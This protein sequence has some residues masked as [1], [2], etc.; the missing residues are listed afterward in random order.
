[1]ADSF[2]QGK[3]PRALL[4]VAALGGSVPL[5]AGEE[6]PG[7]FD[8]PLPWRIGVDGAASAVLGTNGFLRGV[9]EREERIGQSVSGNLRADFSFN[10]AS[11]EG[12]LYRG[13][14]QGIG[15]GMRTFFADDMLGKP[16]SVYVYQGAPFATF[17]R[18]SLGYEWQFGAAFG[19]KYYDRVNSE[20]NAAVS[21]PV[22]A[23]MGVSLKLGYRASDCFD[24]T[25]G[26][27]AAHFSNG[28]TSHPN[29]GVNTVGASVGVAYVINRPAAD[30]APRAEWHP[31]R[32]W[33]VDITS[34][35]SWRKRV[36]NV[37]GEPQ[38]CPGRFGVL[39]LQVAPK[40]RASRYL[41]VGASVGAQYDES[42]DI[43]RYHVEGTVGDDIKFYRPPLGNQISVGVA[44][45]GELTMPFF[46]ID[47]GL[48]VN[49]VN[50]HGEKRFYQ[51]LTLKTFLL[52]CLYLNVGYRL[53]DFK[54]PQNLMLGIGCRL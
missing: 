34:Y 8:G 23:H 18:F 39:G 37:D 35:C 41:A 38:M 2:L 16:V 43:Q 28:N 52:P 21:T 25:A 44:V 50:P 26:V 29:A 9:N 32:R 6:A 3:L 31:S 42:A 7:R 45:H 24:V 48:G 15:V 14:Y 47:A 53:G 13:L 54:D 20:Y 36:V 49:V 1:M 22:T 27:E 4:F 40:W 46:S 10:A 51:S 30:S 33:F 5:V 17:G 19:W 12:R 11:E